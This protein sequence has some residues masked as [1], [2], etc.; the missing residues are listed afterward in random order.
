MRAIQSV[1]NEPKNALGTKQLLFN[2]L[3][4]DDPE[5]AWEDVSKSYLTF[6]EVIDSIISEI[7]KILNTR[8]TAKANEYEDLKNDPLNFGIPSL[9]GLT[10][11]NSFDAT[12]PKQWLKI[13]QLCEMAITTF[14]PRITDVNVKV[15][16][17]N[18]HHQALNIIVKGTVYLHKIREEVRFPLALECGNAR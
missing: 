5:E 6:D 11:F 16:S 18:K 2:L 9:F 15:D 3:V 7:S 8:L 12:S 4:D 17:Y 10:D 13:A 14:E 1:Y